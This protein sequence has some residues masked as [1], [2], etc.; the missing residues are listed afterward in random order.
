V[1]ILNDEK[2]MSGCD[3]DRTPEEVASSVEKI[4]ERAP[5]LNVP[6]FL[7]YSSEGQKGDAQDEKDKS[8]E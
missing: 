4:A 8:A 6:L 2:K 1:Q 5:T 7:R 3:P